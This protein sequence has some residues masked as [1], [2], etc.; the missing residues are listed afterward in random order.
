MLIVPSLQV[1]LFPRNDL[2]GYSSRQRV[3]VL[4]FVLHG[5]Q[6]ISIHWVSIFKVRI[7]RARR[8]PYVVLASNKSEASL[9]S[10]EFR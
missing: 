9:L 3:P 4:L 1:F 7:S 8:A 5:R 6:D 10:Q 2:G